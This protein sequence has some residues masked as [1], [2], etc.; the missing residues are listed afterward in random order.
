MDKIKIGKI[1]NTIGLNGQLKFLLLGTNDA[2]LKTAKNL[3]IGNF[4]EKFEC[5]TF[6]KKSGNVYSL[7]LLDY[8]D[9]NDVEKFKNCDVFIEH[10]NQNIG[11]NQFFVADLVGCQ[12]FFDG[13]N[14][15]I[16]IDV[17]NFGASDIL[18]FEQYKKEFR[19]P[20]VLEY[21]EKVDIK[22]KQIFASDKFLD[23][24]V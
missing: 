23:G 14:A 11:T 2:I 6:S 22:N 9:I 16:V 12:I 3:Y 10:N 5:E 24:V 20:F 1:V 21:I 17:E 13:N 8:N 4:D 18:V 15:G 7:K 19:V